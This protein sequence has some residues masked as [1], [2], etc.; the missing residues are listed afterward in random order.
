MK[1]WDENDVYDCIV[2]GSG[3]A[4]LGAAVA[5]ARLGARVLVLESAGQPGGTI[6]AVPFMPVNRLRTGKM[7]RSDIHEAFIRH[8]T[9]LGPAACYSGPEDRINGDGICMHPEYA[10]LAIYNM[11]DEAGVVLKLFS[12]VIDAEVEEGR[13][14]A[15]ITREKRGLVRYRG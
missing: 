11:L 9:A 5:A 12:P 6:C 8:V 3:P 4:G 13:L 7:P 14:C 15:V 1:K 10:E 2:C